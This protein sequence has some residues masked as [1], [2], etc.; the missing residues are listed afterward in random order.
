MKK[1]NLHEMENVQG[2]L[3]EC[4]KDMIGLGLTFAGAFLVGNVFGAGLFAAGFI[5]GSATLDCSD[6]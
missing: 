6:Y 3:S 5:W 2:G 1:L 4:A